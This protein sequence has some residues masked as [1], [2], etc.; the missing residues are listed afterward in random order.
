MQIWPFNKAD[1]KR[2]HPLDQMPR[3]VRVHPEFKRRAAAYRGDDMTSW[4]AELKAG[5]EVYT[6]L[7]E[8]ADV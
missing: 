3:Q 6:M 7:R 4:A 1:T 5:I 8:G 2:P